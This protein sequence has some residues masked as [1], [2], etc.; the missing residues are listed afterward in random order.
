MRRALAALNDD[1]DSRWGVRIDLRTGV[2]TGEVVVDPAKSA[3]LLVGDTL[4][5]AARLE[6]AAAPGEV[7]VGSETYRLVR[8]DA[9]LEPVPA[10]LELKGKGRPVSAFRLVDGSRSERRQRA[11]L[12]A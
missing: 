5:V 7:L 1:L 12:Q 11:R 9:R 4:N 6:Q 10:P 8:D 2:N 3:D